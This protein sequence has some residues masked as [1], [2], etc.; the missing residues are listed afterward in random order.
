MLR[1]LVVATLAAYT[2]AVSIGSNKAP[3]IAIF[4][5]PSRN[6]DPACG[7][8][9]DYTAASYPKWVESAGGRAVPV[10]YDASDEHVEALF[11]QTNGLLFPGGGAPWSE[12]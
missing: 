4:S 9:C 1:C 5:H 3:I 7:G 12:S 8:A 10:P 11:R 6:E 2:A